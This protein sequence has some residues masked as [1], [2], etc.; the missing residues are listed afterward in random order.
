MMA[1][2]KRHDGQIKCMYSMIEDIYTTVWD[3]ILFEIKSALILKKNLIA[4][5]FTMKIFLK[6]KIRSFG[7]EVPDFCKKEIP[8]VDSSHTCLAV[9]SLDS[10]L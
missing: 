9:I 1:Y 10:A 3:I 4:N 8:K 7:D 2:V 6:I 5:L